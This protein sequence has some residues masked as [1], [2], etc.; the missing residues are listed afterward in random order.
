MIRCLY[1]LALASASVTLLA[2]DV[3]L[4]VGASGEAKYQE[5]F[6]KCR[7]RWQATCK[8]AGFKLAVI[9]PDIQMGDSH[10]QE[11]EGV[12]TKTLSQDGDEPIWLVLV[13]HGTWDGT[14]AKFNL[15]GPDVSAR[16]IATWVRPI[17]RPLVIL[18]CASSSA[19]FVDRLSG[20][21]R[22]VVT[23]TKSGTEQN[24]ARFG[25]FF[26]EAIGKLE[27]DLDHDDSVSV[28]EAFLKAATETEAFYKSEGRIPTEHALLDDNGDKKGSR[29][30]LML[31]KKAIDWKGIHRRNACK[32]NCD[33]L[34]REFAADVA[35]PDS[36]QK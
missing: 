4:V 15:V 21:N 17:E 30:E 3:V 2:D 22:V 1:L 16:E 29:I 31:G 9:G 20:R 26:A 12:L 34:I 35:R 25:T 10:R 19:P 33:S 8:R 11:L 32:P 5:D 23:A 18:N 13:G 24:Y 7:E 27:S 28:R 14:S 6:R 36:T